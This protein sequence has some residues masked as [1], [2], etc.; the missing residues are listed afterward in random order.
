MSLR[1]LAAWEHGH[2]LG[3]LS[4]LLAVAGEFRRQGSEVLWATPAHLPHAAQAVRDAGYA[5]RPAPV[6]R[7]ME[8]AGPLESYVDILNALGFADADALA[9]CVREWLRLMQE[10]R[11]DHVLLDYAPAA[12]LAAHLAGIPSTQISNGFDAPPMQCPPFG[13][14]VRGPFI[15]E[16]NEQRRTALSAR[17]EA[18]SREVNGRRGATLSAMLDH[19]QRWFDCIPQTDPYA[20]SRFVG[21]SD[22][23]IGPQGRPADAVEAAW[24]ACNARG[25]PR[26]FVYLR[27]REVPT[28]VLCALAD[29]GASVLCAW[30]EVKPGDIEE[31]DRR[32]QRVIAGP[33]L[34]DRALAQA[35]WVVNYGSSTL[36]C[37][38]LLAGKGQLMIP[39]DTEKCLVARQVQA[40]GAGTVLIPGRVGATSLQQA[41]VAAL[42]RLD[43][44]SRA[45]RAIAAQQARLNWDE[46]LAVAVGRVLLARPPYGV[47]STASAVPAVL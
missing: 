8:P 18:V 4:R 19:P 26:A 43:D 35:D 22:M 6:S 25:A 42:E 39:S 30:P 11:A 31:A 34:L 32:G 36:V 47:L 28:A 44:A 46:R 29:Q 23:Y 5:V 24:P 33:I 10:S 15:E 1:V 14:G 2:N 3:H 21:C 40:E 38:A 17:V 41:V 16:R 27:G 37:Q 45:A 9:C 7:A 20:E 13:L 12:Q